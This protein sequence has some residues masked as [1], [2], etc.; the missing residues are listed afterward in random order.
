LRYSNKALTY[1]VNLEPII[2]I[3]QSLDLNV[4]KNSYVSRTFG[5]NFEHNRWIKELAEEELEYNKPMPI[6]TK[7]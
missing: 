4:T 2:L 1:S 7:L 5:N 6:S 3:E